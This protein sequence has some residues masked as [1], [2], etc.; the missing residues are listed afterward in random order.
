MERRGDCTAVVCTGKAVIICL[1]ER[2]T[3]LK[4]LKRLNSVKVY[5]EIYPPVSLPSEPC[6]RISA[7]KGWIKPESISRCPN[8]C[9]A[10]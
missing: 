10:E 9:E 3:S 2:M 4:T 7:Y 5:T 6:N 8:V 1:N